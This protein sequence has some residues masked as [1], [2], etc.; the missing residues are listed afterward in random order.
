MFQ[1]GVVCFPSSWRPEEKIGLTV[2]EIHTPVPTLN[3]RLGDQIDKFLRAIK[4]GV[5]WE[6]LNWGLSRSPELNQHPE[7]EIPSL[8]PPYDLNQV[9]VR[10]EDQVLFRLPKTRALIFG[11]N[12]LNISVAEIAAD[13]EGRNRLR[14]AISTMPDEIAKYKN[15]QESRD[16]LL[17]LLKD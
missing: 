11:I 2:Y 8:K 10:R 17:R 3:E 16:H 9:W 5:A 1:A 14:M 15:I 7:C 6:R 13:K 12:I 4:P